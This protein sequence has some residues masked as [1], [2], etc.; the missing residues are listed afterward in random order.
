MFEEWTRIRTALAALFTLFV[1]A[2]ANLLLLP[3]AEAASTDCGDGSISVLSNSWQVTPASL[4]R[5]SNNA[6]GE[7][8]RCEEWCLAS[9]GGFEPQGE[10]RCVSSQ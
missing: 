6:C 1:V 10:F 8:A 2:S 7:G 4:E 3:R 5:D 9:C